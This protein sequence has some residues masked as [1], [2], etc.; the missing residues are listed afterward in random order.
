MDGA[1]RKFRFSL[2]ALTDVF[3]N[4]D[5]ARLVLAW[6]AFTFAGWAFAIALSVYAFDRGGDLAVGIAAAARQ[7]AGALASPFSGLMGDRFSRRLVLVVSALLARSS[8][9][10]AP[11]RSTLIGRAG[12]STRSAPSV[13][14]LSRHT[15]RPRAP[16]CRRS[17]AL[18]RSSRLRTSLTT[19]RATWGS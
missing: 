18:P 5:L 8:S 4:R 12:S 13:R 10:S 14:S 9:G 2:R 16:C 19:R 17:R 3:A 6:G 7:L 15:F 11:T 1:L